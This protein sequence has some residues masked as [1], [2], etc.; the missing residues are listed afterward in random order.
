MTHPDE[1]IRWWA[2]VGLHLPDPDA[3]PAITVLKNNPSFRKRS[4][5]NIPTPALARTTSMNLHS[6][7]TLCRNTIYLCGFSFPIAT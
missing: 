7:D 6:E 3:A 1:G 5:P 4:Y 2:V